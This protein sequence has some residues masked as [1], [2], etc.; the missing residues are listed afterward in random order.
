M[1]IGEGREEGETDGGWGGGGWEGVVEW[2][3]ANKMMACR[4]GDRSHLQALVSSPSAD[5]WWWGWGLP[6]SKLPLIMPAD[7]AAHQWH[8]H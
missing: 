4:E 7:V 2:K 6:S 1:E 8:P 5:L 3:E